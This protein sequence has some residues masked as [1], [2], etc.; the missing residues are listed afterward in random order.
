SRAAAQVSI[1]PRVTHAA[2]R[3]SMPPHVEVRGEFS[4]FQGFHAGA[5]VFMPSYA[6]HAGARG[7]HAGHMGSCWCIGSVP[8]QRRTVHRER[9]EDESEEQRLFDQFESLGDSPVRHSPADPPLPPQPTDQ[10]T[11]PD[12][13]HESDEATWKQLTSARLDDVWDVTRTS[14]SAV[15]D[16]A[17]G[18]KQRADHACGSDGVGSSDPSARFH[19]MPPHPSMQFH[20][21]ARYPHPQHFP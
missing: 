7:F 19:Q 21:P 12:I 3:V 8:S 5:R 16:I 9:Y 4:T 2:A 13:V 20:T 6:F 15:H 17:Q 10:Q 11:Q 14:A 18:F 1:P